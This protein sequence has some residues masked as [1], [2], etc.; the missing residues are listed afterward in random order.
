MPLG[1][2]HVLCFFAYKKNTITLLYI[3][4]SFF[5]GKKCFGPVNWC[6]TIVDLLSAKE[7]MLLNDYANQ[8]VITCWKLTIETRKRGVKYAQS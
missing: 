7:H 1:S 5:Y 4:T 3:S 8:R 2:A 6:F